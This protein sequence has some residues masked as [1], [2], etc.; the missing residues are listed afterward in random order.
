MRLCRWAGVQ[1][2][3]DELGFSVVDRLLHN[4]FNV[5]S[6][7]STVPRIDIMDRNEQAPHLTCFATVGSILHLLR[8]GD[9]VWSTGAKGPNYDLSYDITYHSVRGPETMAVLQGKAQKQGYSSKNDLLPPEHHIGDGA[10]ALPLLFPEYSRLRGKRNTNQTDGLQR[11]IRR[12]FIKHYRDKKED[13]R[14]AKAIRVK[15]PWQAV[16]HRL[17]TECDVVASSSLHGI[18]CGDSIGLPTMWFQWQGSS[19]EGTFKYRDYLLSVGRSGDDLEP[20][21]QLE[22]TLN[23]SAYSKPIPAD[24]RRNI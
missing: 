24:L 3:G 14:G 9:H 1:N 13:V 20:K 2:F 22:T 19:K 15:Q 5:S 21:S 12:C 6:S 11:S 16:L 18:I 17:T 8:P 4:H 23:L 7:C 10:L